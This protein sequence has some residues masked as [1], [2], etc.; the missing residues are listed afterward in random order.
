MKI[1]IVARI[2]LFETRPD[3]GDCSASALEGSLVGGCVNSRGQTGNDAVTGLDHSESDVPSLGEFSRRRRARADDCEA[4]FIPERGK[5]SLGKNN[6]RVI[7]DVKS[8]DG[9]VR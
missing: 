2:S 6:G 9:I 7:V 3:N 1:S 8:L 4:R 5:D